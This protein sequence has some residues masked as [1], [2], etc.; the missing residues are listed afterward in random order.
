MAKH[1]VN[2]AFLTPSVLRLLEPGRVP[3]PQSLAIMGEPA[4]SRDWERWAGVAGV[5]LLEAYGPTEAAICASAA[6]RAP[7]STR[8]RLFNSIGRPF[9]PSW[10]VNRY[11]Q[12]L[13]PIG[14]V[15][16]LYLE[17]PTVARG[18]LTRGCHPRSPDYVDDGADA[19]AESG[20]VFIRSPAW[21]P[22]AGRRVYRT[23]GLAQNFAPDGAL[24]ILG[25]A[26]GQVKIRGRRVGLGAQRL[27]RRR[28]VAENGIGETRS[29]PAGPLA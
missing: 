23:G 11:A 7:G 15:G 4:A 8:T 9:V 2:W 22:F 29:G 5:R 27:P 24:L 28:P 17:G 13:A 18:Y 25:R 6:M 3:S 12:N 20:K 14:A 10:I 16:E 19:D 1:D 26:D 21:H